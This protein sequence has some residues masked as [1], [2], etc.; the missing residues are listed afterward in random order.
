MALNTSDHTLRWEYTGK[1]SPGKPFAWQDVVF[2]MTDGYQVY[3]LN[4]ENGR[5]RFEYAGNFNPSFPVVTGG[6]LYLGSHDGRIYSEDINNYSMNVTASLGGTI[7]TAYGDR[8]EIPAGALSANT[9]VTIGV[10]PNDQGGEGV[11]TLP[12][13]YRLGPDGTSFSSPATAKFAYKTS[14][15]QGSDPKVF[16]IFTNQVRGSLTSKEICCILGNNALP[17]LS[18]CSRRSLPRIQSKRCPPTCLFKSK[19]L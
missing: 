4:M 14:D 9:I 18:N 15:L 13:K 3:G 8:L 16:T 5:L 2:V 17:S 10:S 6:L 1:G 11:V 7:L 12:R 19:R